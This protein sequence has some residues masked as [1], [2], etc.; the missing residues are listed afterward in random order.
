MKYINIKDLTDEQYE[1]LSNLINDRLSIYDQWDEQ[2][3]YDVTDLKVDE[4]GVIYA[5]TKVEI[6]HE[7]SGGDNTI[8]GGFTETFTDLLDYEPIYTILKNQ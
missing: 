7:T 8:P 4:N 5:P 1:D 2:V 3:D 6:R